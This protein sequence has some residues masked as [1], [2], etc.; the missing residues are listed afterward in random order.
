M[1]W[2]KREI[3][4][5]SIQGIRSYYSKYSSTFSNVFQ[6]SYDEQTKFL[7]MVLQKKILDLHYNTLY[8]K[9][10]KNL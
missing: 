10:I 4:L 2:I 6:Q 7:V 8:L 9:E 5:R 3:Q 1:I